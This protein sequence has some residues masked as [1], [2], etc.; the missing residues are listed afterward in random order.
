MEN[1]PILTSHLID[2]QWHPGSYFALNSPPAATF[3]RTKSI[4]CMGV[5]LA[6]MGVE[7]RMRNMGSTLKAPQ[8]TKIFTRNTESTVDGLG[9]LQGICN[10]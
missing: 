2:L 4:I 1:N 8:N 7:Q 10:Q 3:A 5:G 6:C 9:A